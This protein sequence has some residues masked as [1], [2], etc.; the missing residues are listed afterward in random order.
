[1]FEKLHFFRKFRKKEK[2]KVRSDEGG[3]RTNISNFFVPLCLTS[4]FFIEM[5]T[6]TFLRKL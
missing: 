4:L 3:K 5:E 6:Y 2:R 1:M